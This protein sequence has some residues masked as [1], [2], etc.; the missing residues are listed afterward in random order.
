M[1]GV[2]NLVAKLLGRGGLG[3]SVQIRIRQ[4][5]TLADPSRRVL[6]KAGSQYRCRNFPYQGQQGNHDNAQCS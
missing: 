6:D 5:N 4:F 2:V 1:D 3:G